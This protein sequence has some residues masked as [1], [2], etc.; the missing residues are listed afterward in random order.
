MNKASR[1]GKAIV[2]LSGGLDSATTAAWALAEG[3]EITA[4][5]FDYGQRHR[6]ELQA[7][8]AVAND[9]GISDHITLAIDLA[10][11]GGSALVDQS[12]AV[13]KNRSAD[14]ISNGIP[15][16]YVP[17][18]NTVF[19]SLA[20]ALA[21][22]RNASTIILGVN[23][24]DYSG[25]PD[26]RPEFLNA[27]ESLANLATKSGVEGTHLTVLAPLVSLTKTEIIRLGLSL[28]VD[29]GL[30]TSCYDPKE[31]GQPCGECDSCLIREAGFAAVNLPDP[32]VAALMHS[33]ETNCGSDC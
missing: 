5:S 31:T 33:K 6:I 3:Y 4:I 20:L 14:V 13:P 9:L 27:F 26:C 10:A 28:H 24:I 29:Y 19:L 23:S 12:I 30:T 8:K 15:V 17:A 11:F 7:A 32:R 25:Y 1:K 22:T 16:T 18:R 2:L 21:E